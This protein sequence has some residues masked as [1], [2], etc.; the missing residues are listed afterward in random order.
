MAFVLDLR[1]SFGMGRETKSLKTFGNLRGRGAAA[2][3]ANRF[4]LVEIDLD[5]DWVD[6]ELRHTAEAGEEWSP[7]GG[8]RYYRDH[9]RGIIA[10]N[11]SPDIGFDA[12]INPYRGCEHGCVYCYARPTHEYLGLSAGLDFES[13]IFVKTDAA[14][15]LRRELSR[16]KWKPQVIAISGVTDPYQPVERRLRI[17]RGCLEVLAEARNPVGIVT[18]NHLV[19]RDVD[20]LAELARHRAAKVFVSVTTLDRELQRSMEPRTSTPERRLEAIRTLSAAGVPV[21]VMVAPVI[22]GLTDHELPRILEAAADAGAEAAGWVPL[23]LPHGVK[24]LFADWLERMHPERA[25]RVLNRVREIRG[26]ELYDASYH[27]RLRGEGVYA[28]HLRALFDSACRRHGLNRERP[29][30]STAAF[31]RPAPPAPS[32]TPSRPLPAQLGLFDEG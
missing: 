31:R 5:G 11:Q 25:S 20:L 4:E 8:T 7:A 19:T 29:G 32:A 18:K 22:P 26:G 16:P 14:L 2:N 24:D 1:Y 21:G 10:R 27:S 6:E 17:T 30:L 23:R 12:S 15:L 9:T 28:D 3:P 13:R